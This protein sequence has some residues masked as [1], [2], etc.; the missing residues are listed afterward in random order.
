MLRA[1]VKH[2]TLDI[3]DSSRV[4]ISRVISLQ[5]LRTELTN[6]GIATLRT[7]CS[8][9]V[10]AFDNA[11][12]GSGNRFIAIREQAYLEGPKQLHFKIFNLLEAAQVGEER[13]E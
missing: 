4:D 2:Y 1:Y 7:I 12:I 6:L 5:V 9:R 11:I 10:L 8:N 3:T 13:V